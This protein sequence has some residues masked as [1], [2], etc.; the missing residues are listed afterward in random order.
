MKKL[1]LT[2]LLLSGCAQTKIPASGF[3][4][5]F[6]GVHA[7]EYHPVQL[8]A[9]GTLKAQCIQPTDAEYKNLP[10]CSCE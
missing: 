6:L 10:K 1:L 7:G 8:S 3:P 2:T 9:T 4:I 5:A